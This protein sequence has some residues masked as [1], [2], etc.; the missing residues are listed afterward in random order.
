MPPSSAAS[1]SDDAVPKAPPPSSV[2]LDSVRSQPNPYRAA[3]SIG[4]VSAV[5]VVEAYR[6]YTATG[7]DLRFADPLQMHRLGLTASWTPQPG[8]P[9]SE[10]LHV[11]ARYTRYDLG[12]QFRWNPASFYDLAGPT[13]TSR[14]GYNTAVDWHRSLMRDLPRTLDLTLRL[15]HWGGLQRLPDHQNVATS[16]GFDQ[17]L[18]NSAELRY[19][20][21]RGSLGAV[22]AEVGHTWFA[23]LSSNDV[24]VHRPGGAEWRAY[25]F[26]EAGVD[27]GAP[28]PGLR[29][30]SLWL[31]SAAGYS[32]GD[33]TEPFANFYFGA[34]GN[35]VLDRQD[36]KRYR[37]P[38][39][40]PGLAID[41]VGGTNYARTMLDWNLPPLRF[42]RA[43]TLALYATWARVS[44]FGSVLGTNLDDAVT[45]SRVADLGAQMD[46]RLQFLTLDPL[47]LSFGY[48]RAFERHVGPR[49]EAMVSLKVL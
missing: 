4:L 40:F 11:T 19:K 5:P 15:S 36:P 45:R 18:A 8:V 23:T 41:E 6:H 16:S 12:V 28:V 9:A 24:R 33:R 13:Q 31:R 34:F 3:A 1:E 7:L 32:P 39:S 47:T 2:T 29:H 27:V 37:D 21:L 46:I 10:R 22:E 20:H 17:L 30:S 26:A 14:K 38:A 48:A 44:L 49:H 35:N 42:R 43:G 25:P